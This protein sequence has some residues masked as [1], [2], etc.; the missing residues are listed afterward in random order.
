MSQIKAYSASASKARVLP[1]EIERRP[2]GTN[3]VQIAIEHCGVCHTDIHFVNNDWGMTHYPVVPGHE[4]VGRVTEVGSAVS[5]FQVGDRAAIGC[6][7]D[8][9]GVC[10]NCEKGLEQYCLNGF[11]AT[12][13]SETQDPGGFTYGG[14]SQSIVAKE[15][16]VLKVP[17]SLNGPGI[18]P[19]L[20][21]GITTYSPLKN[22]KIGPESKVGVIGLGGLGHMGVKFSHALGA[23]TTMITSSEQKGEDARL[24]GADEVLLSSSVDALVQEAGSFDF[25]LNTIPVNHDLTPYL[26]L[27]KTNGTMCVV[28]AV[29]PLSQVNAAQLIFGRR[30][31]SGSLIGGI[32]ETQEMLNFCGEKNILSEVEVIRMDEINDAYTRMQKNQVKYRFVLDLGSL[33]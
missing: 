29:E 33:N 10:S 20:C 27:L 19:L 11:T 8:S 32:A 22:W 17:D 4:I 12:Y 3:D 28:G 30:S 2:V 15:S 25:L 21:A 31:L 23:H 26:E 5:N 7:V 1:T 13:N 16:F 9:C 6:L 14:Y 18:A 24:L